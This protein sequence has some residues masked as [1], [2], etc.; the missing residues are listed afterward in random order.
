MEIE[1]LDLV[2]F[3]RDNNVVVSETD[4]FNMI[5]L[6]CGKGTLSLID[7]IKLICPKSQSTFMNAKNSKVT[8]TYGVLPILSYQQENLVS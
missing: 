6:I 4:C 7:F 3:F 5:Q 1:S 2:L 8:A